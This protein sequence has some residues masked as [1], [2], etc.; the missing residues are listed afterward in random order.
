LHIKKRK[1]RR[2]KIKIAHKKRKKRR[3]NKIAHAC[4]QREDGKSQV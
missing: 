1:K 4:V 3:K 2:K